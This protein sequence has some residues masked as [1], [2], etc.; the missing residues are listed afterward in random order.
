ML[1]GRD[2]GLI[3]GVMVRLKAFDGYCRGWAASEGQV[4][5]GVR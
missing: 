5:T 3:V 1:R 4:L 2:G